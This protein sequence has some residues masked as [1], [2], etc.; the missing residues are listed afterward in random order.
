[1]N[2]KMP[3]D[4]VNRPGHYI[5]ASVTLEPIELTGR[6][7]SCTGQALNYIFRAPYKGN[8]LEDIEKAMFYLKKSK[9]FG[10]VPWNMARDQEGVVFV[11]AM[12]FYKNTKDERLKRALR[13][14]FFEK[15]DS[16]N[17]YSGQ[18]AVISYLSCDRQRLMRERMREELKQKRLERRMKKQQEAQNDNE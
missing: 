2:D 10:I 17:P 7:D 8:E 6:L 14:L 16:E 9:C 12:L 11:L 4:N 1:M 3:I 13:S 5:A 18:D 15:P